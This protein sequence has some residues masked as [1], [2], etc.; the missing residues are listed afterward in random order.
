MDPKHKNAL[1][2][3][4][5]LHIKHERALMPLRKGQK[6]PLEYGWRE[7]FYSKDLLIRYVRRGHNVAWK[8]GEL[9]LVI[10]IDPRHDDTLESLER[11]KK[12]WP[13]IDQ[14]PIVLTGGTDQGTHFY[15]K[16]PEKA[17]IKSNLYKYPGIDFRHIG[18]YVVIAHSR[19]PSGRYYQWDLFSPHTSKALTVPP[20]LFE[21]LKY[22]TTETDYETHTISKD[23][24]NLISLDTL[25][26]Y[27]NQLEV[28]AYQDYHKW[29]AIAMSCHAA[30]SGDGLPVFLDWCLSDPLY[31]DDEEII[32]HKWGGFSDTNS[33][34]TLGTLTK[35][36]LEAGGELKHATAVEDF[37]EAPI[38][39]PL[40]P[41]T[42]ID[43][44]ED[45]VDHIGTLS[46]DDDYEDLIKQAVKFGPASWDKIRRTI[47]QSFGVTYK[48]IDAVYTE[49]QRKRRKRKKA[50]EKAESPDYGILVANRVLTDRFEEGA[51][52]LHARNQSFYHYVGTHWELLPPNVVDKYTLETAEEIAAEPKMNFKPS[53]AIPSAERVLVAKSAHVN[54]VLRLGSEPPACINTLNAEVW[55]DK[56]LG[57]PI[58][59]E[60]DPKSYLLNCLDT[61]YDPDSTCPLFDSTMLEI[62][63][64]NTE[65]AEMVRH[66][67]E[68]FGYVIQPFKNIPSWWIFHG[69]GSNGKTLL[70]EVVQAILGDAVL[71]RPVAD[72]ADTQRNNHATANLVGKLLVLDDDADTNAFL[73]ESALK[74]L[75]ESK[76]LESNPKARDAFT[77]R[78]TATPV[79]LINDW[80]RMK[81]LSH[82]MLRKSYVMPF[83]R[84]F[85]TLEMDLGRKNKIIDTELPGV[86]NR[87]LEG[88]KR[89]RKR[90]NFAEPAECIAAKS[91]WLRLANPLMEFVASQ[92]LKAGNG[93]YSK[94]GDLYE[95][96]RL[97]CHNQ[98]GVSH[99]LMQNRF[100]I[101]LLQLGYRTSQID[102]CKVFNGI[103]M[104]S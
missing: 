2:A 33:G 37:L 104:K 13:E 8:L 69:R 47:K 16:L 72:F 77:F 74:K 48:T 53:L 18:Q 92:T 63:D 5:K 24:P 42:R 89:L 23:A 45:F 96:Y 75:S 28:T 19:H 7:R 25:R 79:V 50:I 65:P 52:L 31:S 15:L 9:D 27:L 1:V 22:E 46:P 76:L 60:H 98:G 56:D 57:E 49:I 6:T 26:F 30:T 58:V 84:S 34:I 80:P 21:I 39:E 97:W 88:Y 29:L 94:V 101:S 12:D 40:N 70:M 43:K 95:Q 85:D 86:L 71:P 66:F 14:T 64:D 62:F 44:F 68:F 90:G 91:I 81:D 10:D 73:P 54:D 55:L 87:A 51:H 35:A 20:W 41:K 78:S 103:E 67:L 83:K 38:D 3:D 32:I 11:L 102:D 36:V 93:T 17:K 82:G 99:P 4:L 59:K 100:E 61:V